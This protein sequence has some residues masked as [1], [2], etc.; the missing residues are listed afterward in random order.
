MNFEIFRL[1]NPEAEPQA[2]QPTWAPDLAVRLIC[3]DCQDPVPNLIEEY[4]SGDI[5][6]GSCG[7]VLSGRV[8]DT[9]SEWRVSGRIPAFG[10]RH[11]LRH[12]C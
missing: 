5:V 6:C 10:L 2:L 1:R 7:L 8:I 3:P 12:S 11:S 4:S 9:R